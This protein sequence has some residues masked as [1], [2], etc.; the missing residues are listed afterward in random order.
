V[1]LKRQNMFLSCDLKY[2]HV[3][4][5]TKKASEIDQENIV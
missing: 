3:I 1:K 5:E 4:V 2:F